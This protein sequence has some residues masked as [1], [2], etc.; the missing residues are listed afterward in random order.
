MLDP[1][2]RQRT[3]VKG[4]RACFYLTEA[5]KDGAA[6]LFGPRADGDIHAAA[7]KVLSEQQ[8]F[9]GDL[10]RRLRDAAG[11]GSQIE[12]GRQLVADAIQEI[13]ETSGLPTEATTSDASTEHARVPA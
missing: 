10:K 11:S 5:V 13:G 7:V 3:Q 4:D 2:W 1:D 9:D 6:A 12:R 8:A